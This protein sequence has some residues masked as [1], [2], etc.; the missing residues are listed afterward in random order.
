MAENKKT[1]PKDAIG[2]S[3]KIKEAE[4]ASARR[5]KPGRV[6][7]ILLIVLCVA[8]V[9]ALALLGLYHAILDHYLDQMN[10][11]TKEPEMI[12]ATTPLEP[13]EDP[14]EEETV[15]EIPPDLNGQL[16]G[17][18][19][20]LICNTKDVKNFLLLAT[21]NRQSGRAGRSDVMILVS[22]NQK[23]GKITLCSFLR[24]LYVRYPTDPPNPISGGMDKL[25]HAFAYGGATLTMAV[26][27]EAFNVEVN[28]YVHVDFTSFIQ[29]VD[30]IGGLDVE[31]SADE[32][33]Y[34]NRMVWEYPCGYDVNALEVRAG[35]HHLNGAQA[36]A[37]AR[38]RTIGSDWARTQRQR[39]LI[40]LL[41]AKVGTL[42]LS[43]LNEFLETA[44]PLITTN[45]PKDEI[46]SLVSSLPGYMQYSV[47]STKIPQVG[48]YQSV[49]YNM[50]PDLSYNCHYLYE[51]IYG[52]RAEGDPRS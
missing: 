39:T 52:T 40:Q 35:K 7:K 36:L 32:V 44:L 3:K 25:N 16:N 24:D 1:D 14:T 15:T 13:E 2:K 5:K 28:Q 45:I 6:Y 43:Q 8:A 18:K 30:A 10:I 38:N 9:V 41:F 31:L 19:L 26:F 37:H 22:I 46:K 20:P 21:D 47:E 17:E 27:K 11:V 33:S 48:T 12:F 34:V 50:I 23:T 49:K 4:D 51:V 42:S 29:V